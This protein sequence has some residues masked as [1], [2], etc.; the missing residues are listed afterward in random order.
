MK[1]PKYFICPMSKQIVDA[2]ILLN[3]KNFGLLPTRR[4]I[5]YDGGYV[6]NWDT[7]SFNNYVKTKN[8]NIILERDHAGPNQ[9]KIDDNG[10]ISY[11]DDMKYFDIIHID[12][13]KYYSLNKEY[14]I[15]DTMNTIKIL[16]ELNTNIR[17]EILTEE[18]ILKF[19]SDEIDFI[20]KHFSKNL[21]KSIFEKIE[22][23]V[24][25]SGVGLDLVNMKNTGN[26]NLERLKSMVDV[27]KRFGKQTKEHN[28]DYLSN[29]DYKIRFDNGV[30]SIN[31]GPEIAQLQTLVYLE[32]MTPNQIDEFYKICLDSKKWEKWVSKDFDISNKE[33]LIQ[34]CGHYCYDLFDMPYVDG[35]IVEKIQ[36]K[37]KSLP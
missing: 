36:N 34:I 16:Y 28:G 27:C 15:N 20:L 21:E 11:V 2:V 4:Q 19:E 26:F 7:K 18:A 24:I 1:N 8:S 13:W 17:Y 12:P 22:Y 23:V 35:I 6:N 37:L 25:Q 9:G 10:F 33:T 5:D 32:H 29:E 3:S 30:D 14:G 31:I